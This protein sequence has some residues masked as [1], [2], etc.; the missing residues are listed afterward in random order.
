M[1]NQYTQATICDILGVKFDLISYN[2]VLETIESWLE[3][4]ES[5]YITLTNPYCVTL[6]RK[7]P[8]MQK[9]VKMAQLTLPD[10]IGIVLAARML[11]YGSSHC[12]RVIGP[13]LMLKLCDLGRRYGYRHYFY[14]GTDRVAKQL[15]ERLSKI[16][17]GLE[18][19]G[20]YC[21]PFRR[22]LAV[23]DKHIV[24]KINSTKP[25]IVW[26]GLGAPKQEIWMSEHI[27]RITATA[28]IGVG[29]AFDYHSGNA[30]WAP[31]W[32]RDYGLEW[33][34]GVIYRPRRS[35]IKLWGSFLFAAK[36][37]SFCI[38]QK[39]NDWR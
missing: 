31:S 13:L 8:E 37:S 2:S 14:G 11:G 33:L 18:I 29:A 10:G 4:N 7:D 36:V 38:K 28:M 20:T 27:G 15:A 12:H 16:Y 3:R 21:P 24:E 22:L 19:A 9:A 6:C 5:H 17:P 30:R 26:V 34:H 23:E 35:V 39:S 25:D 1:N 32:V